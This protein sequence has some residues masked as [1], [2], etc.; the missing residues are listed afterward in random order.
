MRNSGINW[1]TSGFL[2]TTF[3]IAV[4]TTPLYIFELGFGALELGLFLVMF[5]AGGLSITAGYH[6]LFTHCTYRAPWPVRLALVL[7]GAS[8]FESSALLWSSDHRYHHKFSDQD[9]DP[10]DPHNIHHGFFWAHMGWMLV[11]HEPPN[12]RVNV[13]D[14]RR[15][16]IVMWQHKYFVLVA[17]AM[18]F[19]MPMAVAATVTTLQG[20]GVMAGLMAGFVWGG[21][22]RIVAI[23]HATFLINSA[24][25]IV[26]RQPYDSETTARDNGLLA[27]ITFGEGYHNFHHSF[28]GDYRIGARAWHWDPGKWMIWFLNRVGLANSLRR[29]PKETIALVKIQEARRKLDR[30]IERLQ[31]ETR[32]HIASVLSELEE[33]LHELHLELRTLLSE[34]ARLAR[35]RGSARRAEIERQLEQFSNDFR[36]HVKEWKRQRRLL[37]AAVPA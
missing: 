23:M 21:C 33:K 17:I 6:R 5:L 3:V 24:A 30:R 32:E 8:T 34:K 25:H 19:A 29:L 31:P 28:P 20:K 1:V 35:E 10:H 9:G 16:P 14:L 26:G 4:I 7:F 27:L 15:D 18:G 22:T 13:D 11:H 2:I 12:P 36:D 37:L